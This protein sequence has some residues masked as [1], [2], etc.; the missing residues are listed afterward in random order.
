MNLGKEF[1]S[2]SV[3]QLKSEQVRVEPVLEQK[4]QEKA[5]RLTQLKKSTLISKNKMIASVEKSRLRRE[6]E[7]RRQQDE[8]HAL[9]Q[10]GEEDVRSSL[11]LRC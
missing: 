5:S 4:F 1:L 8:K 6:A 3:T 2:K 11:C 7:E 9:L 10:A